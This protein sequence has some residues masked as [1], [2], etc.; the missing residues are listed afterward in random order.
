MRNSGPSDDAFDNKGV[1]L[2]RDF[3]VTAFGH[4]I[5]ADP[6]APSQARAA[7]L[8]GILALHPLNPGIW[9]WLAS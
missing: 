2:D 9:L 5:L 1:P 4:A 6:D 8:A 7:I 3:P